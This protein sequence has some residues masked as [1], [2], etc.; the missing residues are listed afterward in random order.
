MRLSRRERRLALLAA[1]IAAAVVLKLA[2]TPLVER[3]ESLDAAIEAKTALLE[4]YGKVV[5]QQKELKRIRSGLKHRISELE[6]SL[7]TAPTPTLASAGL[8]SILEG[9]A[10]K[11]AVRIQSVKTMKPE[12]VGDYTRITVEITVASDIRPLLEL[13]YN[14][15]NHPKTLSIVQMN[16]TPIGP[17]TRRM[18]QAVLRVTAGVKGTDSSKMRGEGDA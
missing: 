17:R 11:S 12:D 4:R 7:L 16:I 10:K 18:L 5:A 15:E 14:I 6:N 13:F 1:V 2:V 3:A 8:Q 9:L